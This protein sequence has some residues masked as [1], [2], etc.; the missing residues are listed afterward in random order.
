[1]RE[2]ELELPLGF[3][4]TNPGHMVDRCACSSRDIELELPQ[5]HIGRE[6]VRAKPPSRAINR[7]EDKLNDTSKEMN[8]SREQRDKECK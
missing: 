5:P 3:S 2:C 4:T 8:P 7:L 1:M 6:S